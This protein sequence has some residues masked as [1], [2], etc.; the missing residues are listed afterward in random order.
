MVI[1]IDPGSGRVVAVFDMNDLRAKIGIP[2]ADMAGEDKKPDVMNGIA[3][4]SAGN[5]VFITGK[6]WPKLFE[7][8]FDN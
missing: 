6:Y 5:R 1:K 4:D 3:Y 7:V 8:K 2:A